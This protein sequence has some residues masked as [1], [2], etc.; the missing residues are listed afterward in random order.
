MCR[1]RDEA[2]PAGGAGA[3]GRA[4]IRRSTRYLGA[5][6]RG[7]VVMRFRLGA[8]DRR[9]LSRGAPFGEPSRRDLT[10]VILNW[11]REKP[12]LTLDVSEASHLLS[13]R[14]ET[15]QA[16]SVTSR[17]QGVYTV[18]ATADTWLP[19][20]WLNQPHTP[21]V[22]GR[23]AGGGGCDDHD[24]LVMTKVE[25][26]AS[27]RG[28]APPRAQRAAA[29]VTESSFTTETQRHGTISRKTLYKWK[30][31]RSQWASVSSCHPSI[32]S[33]PASHLVRWREQ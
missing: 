30:R 14:V 13:V 12:D 28:L 7:D 2:L 1:G 22:P 9:R 21:R 8:P 32:R 11:Y 4:L 31:L 25:G 10:T 23:M 15:S 26:A 17:G 20:A 27:G 16:V 3:A 33:E 29:A 5:F 19:T 24:P 6:S 18:R